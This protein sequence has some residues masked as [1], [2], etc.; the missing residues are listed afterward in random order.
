[1]E[2][3]NKTERVAVYLRVGSREQLSESSLPKQQSKDRGGK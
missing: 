3:Q 2:K 1:M